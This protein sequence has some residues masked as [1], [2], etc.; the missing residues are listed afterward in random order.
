MVNKTVLFADDE[1][2]QLEPLKIKIATLG[3]RVLTAMTVADAIESLKANVVDVLVL[4]IMMD[5][6][7]GL[8]GKL[9]PSEAGFQC[10]DMVKK[11][12]PRTQIIY[13]S[14][15]EDTAMLKEIHRK[16]ALYLGKGETSLRK[17]VSVIQSKL[18]GL[19]KD[20]DLRRRGAD[21]RS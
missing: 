13:L 19:I 14:V 5:P 17:T 1:Q 7:E 18:T 11:V 9:S 16:G 10:L 2:S 8:R 4:D 3:Y 15:K 20:S 6:G 21:W 12:S